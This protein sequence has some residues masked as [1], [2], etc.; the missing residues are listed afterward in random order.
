MPQGGKLT[1]TSQKNSEAVQISFSDTGLGIP[2]EAQKK[3][4]QPL[5]TTK[6]KGMGF[7][8]AIC[9]RI[10]EAHRGKILLESTVNKGTRFIIELPI[11][12][13]L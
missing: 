10:V 7:G 6:A 1:V 4:F 5:F 13:K 8:L 2:L 3:V 9:Q 12:N 11:E